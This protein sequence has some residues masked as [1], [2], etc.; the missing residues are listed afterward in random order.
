MLKEVFCEKQCKMFYN[1]LQTEGYLFSKTIVLKGQHTRPFH[2]V[3]RL[4]SKK[5]STSSCTRRFLSMK[6]T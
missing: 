1:P 6:E 4:M 5:L 2:V 3:Y